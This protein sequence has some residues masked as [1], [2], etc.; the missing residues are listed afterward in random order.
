MIKEFAS[1]QSA[2]SI[3]EAL[4]TEEK[5]LLELNIERNAVKE[6][7]EDLENKIREYETLMKEAKQQ[8]NAAQK[9]QNKKDVKITHQLKKVEQ[10][11]QDF[12]A[13]T[14]TMK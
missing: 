9:M 4:Y 10:L 14:H 2:A 3:K 7:I 5:E 8:I 6:Q 1:M 13:I 11:K 12:N